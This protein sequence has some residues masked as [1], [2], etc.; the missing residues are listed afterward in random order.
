MS[1]TFLWFS[2]KSLVNSDVNEKLEWTNIIQPN[3]PWYD[4][5]GKDD[6]LFSKMH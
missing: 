5:Y 1:Y 4:E 2:E 3:V 6:E